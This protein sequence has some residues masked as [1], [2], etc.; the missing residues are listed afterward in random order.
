[1]TEQQQAI[2]DPGR[3]NFLVRVI[4]VVQGVMAATLVF[5]LGGTIL[6]PSFR[7]RQESWLR[8]SSLSAL[9]ENEPLAVTLR[10]ARQ[11]GYAQVVDRTIVY[12]VRL[13][14]GDVRALSST[15]THLGCRTAY[16]RESRQIVCPCHGGI[17]D[18]H[19]NVVEG[20]PPEPLE[21]LKTRIENDEVFV[22]V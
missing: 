4:T 16:D 8:A 21:P 19:G 20:P 7:R 9:R 18:I 2:A 10:V 13:G 11:D 15:C 3:R 12:L 1:M 5:V 17:F 6:A 22:Q 14:E